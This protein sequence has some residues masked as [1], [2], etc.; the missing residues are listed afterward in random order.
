[1]VD[2]FNNTTG[3]PGSDGVSDDLVTDTLVKQKI[4][5]YQAQQERQNAAANPTLGPGVVPLN[6]VL[7]GD[8]TGL[9]FG[10]DADGNLVPLD[11]DGNPILLGEKDQ[12]FPVRVNNVYGYDKPGGA[13][14]PSTTPY[15]TLIK[16]GFL[17]V[18]DQGLIDRVVGA[19]N[20]KVDLFDKVYL[21]AVQRASLRQRAG[22]D[23]SVYDILDQWKKGGLPSSVSTGSGGSGGPYSSTNRV[24]SLSDEGTARRLLNGA[25]TTYLGRTATDDENAMFLKALN[26]QERQNPS[27]TKTTGNTSGRNTT[28]SQTVTGGMDK[29]DFAE[30]FAKS[31]EGY[32]EYQ[33][34][35]TYLDAF[36]G[37]LEDNARVVG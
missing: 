19:S 25:L 10:K 14:V 12:S 26:V 4:R 16:D 8:S 28:Q 29:N 23:V 2:N 5:A 18:T 11:A 13:P 20:G 32:A 1:M 30:R 24:V 27:I 34:A 7:N 33:A 15:K 31:Q 17:G 35:T 9:R 3:L 6:D 37:S 21:A 36:I 22:E